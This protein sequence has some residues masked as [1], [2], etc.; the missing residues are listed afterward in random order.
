MKRCNY[1]IIRLYI[2]FKEVLILNNSWIPLISAI[3]GGGFTIIVVTINQ[4]ISHFR[5]KEE[6]NRKGEDKYLEKRLEILH[7]TIID[8]YL[9]AEEILILARKE[10][11][12]EQMHVEDTIFNLDS[13]IRITIARTSAYVDEIES[14][15]ELSPLHEQLAIIRSKDFKNLS[16]KELDL[17]TELFYLNEEV[18]NYREQLI[19]AMKSYN[20]KK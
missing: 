16:I 5:W 14:I 12:F 18:H 8:L 3:I 6:L 7:D 15:N 10:N 4:F 2:K 13:K 1:E 9:I 17:R 19:N 11:M 20:L